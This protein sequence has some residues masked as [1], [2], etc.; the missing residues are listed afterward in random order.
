MLVLEM[1]LPLPVALQLKLLKQL[2]Q[3][4]RSA[5]VVVVLQLV[6]L[7]LHL[8]MVLAPVTL[9]AYVDTLPRHLDSPLV[10]EL[11][12]VQQAEEAKGK[13]FRHHLCSRVTQKLTV[14][15]HPLVDISLEVQIDS[16]CYDDTSHLLH[17]RSRLHLVV[18][19]PS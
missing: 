15:L 5:V 12:Q 11:D 13:A 9:P 18:H 10:L 16:S 1:E 4:Y 14:Q 8:L 6:R 3:L 7:A 2:S 17:S 19:T